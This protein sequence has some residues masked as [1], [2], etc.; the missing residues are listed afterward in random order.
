MMFGA[1]YLIFPDM[2]APGVPNLRATIPDRLVR[3][4]DA[5]R[6]DHPGGD[7]DEAAVLSQPPRATVPARRDI[8]GPRGRAAAL[9]AV[10]RASLVLSKPPAILL[11][12][13][14]VIACC[15]RSWPWR[16]SNALFYRYV[17]T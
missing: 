10:C 16:S 9:L 8:D 15:S 5:H 2:R 11:A 4:V 12:I 1:M 14:L 13:T 3:R 17:A 6:P 7:P